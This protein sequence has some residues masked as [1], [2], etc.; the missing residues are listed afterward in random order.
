MSV[1]QTA[2]ANAS[3]RAQR[4]AEIQSAVKI[5]PADPFPD[6]KIAFPPLDDAEFRQRLEA[7]AK[8][9]LP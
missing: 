5:K 8:K 9:M 4:V 3:I 6:P 2:A 7:Q 1:K